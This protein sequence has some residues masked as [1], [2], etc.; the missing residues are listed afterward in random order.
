MRGW[1]RYQE[2]TPVGTAESDD[3]ARSKD[4]F[5]LRQSGLGLREM[6]EQRVR[7]DSIDRFIAER[8]LVARS[9]LEANVLKPLGSRK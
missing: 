6:L 3:A 7:E 4:P 2:A 1:R 5:G 8:N 9:L